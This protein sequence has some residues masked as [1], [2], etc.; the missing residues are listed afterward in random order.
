MSRRP[1]DIQKI[2]RPQSFGVMAQG[3]ARSLMARDSR[4][5]YFWNYVP[6]PKLMELLRD[7]RKTTAAIGGN[8]STKSTF[9]AW[10]TVMIYTG[11][12]PP[13]AEGVYP[14]KIPLN[15]PRRVRII[16]Q[17]YTKHWPLTIK[18]LLLGNPERGEE[19]MLPEAWSDFDDEEH[20]FYGP[21]GSMLSIDAVDPNKNADPRSLR[22]PLLDHTWIDEICRENVYT[23]SLT[24]GVSLPDGPKTVMLTFCPQEGYKCWTYDTLYLT[25]YDKLTDRRLP[26]EQQ[27]KDIGVVR[28]SMKDNPSISIEQREA[29]ISTLKDY[30]IAF[31]VDGRYSQMAEN[32]YFDMDRLVAWDRESKCNDG[33]PYRMVEDLIDTD[34]GIFK[35][36]FEYCEGRFDEVHHPIWRL[37]EMP[38]HGHKYVVSADTADGNPN[39]DWQSCSVWDFTDPKKPIQVAHLNIQ[40]LK[41]GEFGQQCACVAELYQ[42]LLVPEVNNTSGGTFTDRVRNYSRLYVRQTIRDK[43][44]K[45]MKKLGWHTDPWNKGPLL[46]TT[47]RLLAKCASKGHCPFKSR[48][49]LLEFMGFEERIERDEKGKAKTVWG[50]ARGGFDDCCME[51]CIGIR[52]GIHERP[53][54]FT[55]KIE[56]TVLDPQHEAWRRRNFE[57]PKVTGH[58]AFKGLKKQPSLAK[59]R[60]GSARWRTR[61]NTRV[62]VPTNVP[63]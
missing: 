63:A 12:V 36:H 34:K 45:Q 32:P 7:D 56:E 39:S 8:K 24:R 43:S 46:E 62:R 29:I 5:E 18:P 55:C 19:G 17:D 50:A 31:R 22:G 41:P 2:R 27:H 42:A 11:L 13:A 59:L 1:G 20:I 16:V 49:T 51:A 10:V 52:V 14:H 44:E 53:K 54:L 47:Y 23:E 40:L 60:G 35:G 28:V 25:G 30:E 6:V 21:D 58:K 15:R 33:V 61:R 38:E 37:W 26:R 48:A 9:G 57:K 3:F 4:Y